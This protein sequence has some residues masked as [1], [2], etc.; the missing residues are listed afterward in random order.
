[1]E[2]CFIDE[3]ETDS[4]A[5][6][7]EAASTAAAFHYGSTSDEMSVNSYALPKR[8]AAHAST[9][10]LSQ[11]KKSH[12]RYTSSQATSLFRCYCLRWRVCSQSVM[13][14]VRIISVRLTVNEVP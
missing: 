10:V 12:R 9:L 5:V 11:V 3:A 2:M 7:S 13:S 6:D 8:K 1:M 4:F 14:V